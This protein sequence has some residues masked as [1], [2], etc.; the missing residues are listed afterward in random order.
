MTARSRARRARAA[1]ALQPP[2]PAHG[3]GS[4]RRARSA[5]GPPTSGIRGAD[6]VLIGRSGGIERDFS[7]LRAELAKALRKVAGK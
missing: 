6:H 5:A 7:A 2:I 3:P 4:P 1:P